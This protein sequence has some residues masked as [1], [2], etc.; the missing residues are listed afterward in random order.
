SD[1]AD[2][3][4]MPMKW[5]GYAALQSTP[6]FKGTTPLKSFYANYCTSAMHSFQTTGDAPACAG[7]VA[8]KA[9]APPNNFPFLRALPSIAPKPNADNTMDSYYPHALGGNRAATRC[10][11]TGQPGQ[12][13]CDG[14]LKCANGDAN[15]MPPYRDQQQCAVTVLDHYTSAFSWAD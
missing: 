5:S 15:S 12:Y 3:G 13:D 11:P 1:M 14:V 7:I 2:V 6:D 4:M 9:N 8:A 10:K